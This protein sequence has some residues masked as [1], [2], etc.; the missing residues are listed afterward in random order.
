[1]DTET[2]YICPGVMLDGTIWLMNWALFTAEAGKVNRNNK[3]KLKHSL[4]VFMIRHLNKIKNP[5]Y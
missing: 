5:E 1:M 2:E 3:I 4:V